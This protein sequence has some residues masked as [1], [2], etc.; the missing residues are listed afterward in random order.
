MSYCGCSDL[1]ELGQYI[2]CNVKLDKTQLKHQKLSTFGRVTISKR[3]FLEALTSSFEY[4]IALRKAHFC[5]NVF[6]GIHVN[7]SVKLSNT[8]SICVSKSDYSAVVVR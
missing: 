3:P 5:S 6:N 4:L 1:L 7:L 8:L 2:H